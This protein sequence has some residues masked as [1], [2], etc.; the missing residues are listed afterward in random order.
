LGFIFFFFF[1]FCF[2]SVIIKM[3]NVNG[4]EDG[5]GSPSGGEEGGVEGGGGGG[6]LEEGMAAPGGAHGVSPPDLMGQSPPHSPR[7]T[8]SPLMF[9]PQVSSF[10]S[11]SLSLSLFFS[12]SFLFKCMSLIVI[13]LSREV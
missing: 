12:A 4:R 7:A 1:G 13:N 5:S 6:C 10:L 2:L 3:G 11:L 9:T 8:Q